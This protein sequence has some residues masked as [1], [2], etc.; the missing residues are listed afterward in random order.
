MN[1][2]YR[3]EEQFISLMEDAHNGNWSD[4]FRQAEQH[5]FFAQDLIR[6]YEN[7]VE[8]YGWD[9]EDLIYIAEG[10]QKLR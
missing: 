9:F 6:H 7:T 1:K 2:E 5:G 4:A 10:A 3:T 8:I